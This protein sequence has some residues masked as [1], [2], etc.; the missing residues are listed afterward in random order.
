MLTKEELQEREEAKKWKE[1][2]YRE[3]SIQ[4]TKKSVVSLFDLKPGHSVTFRVSDEGNTIIEQ[5]IE[6]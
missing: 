6:L 3:K 5:F 2:F 4:R 1:N